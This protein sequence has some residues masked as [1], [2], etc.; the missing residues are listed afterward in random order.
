MGLVV[1]NK[2]TEKVISLP[3]KLFEKDK[4]EKYLHKVV[5]QN[6]DLLST[7]ENEHLYLLGSHLTILGSELD[8]LVVDKN[9]SLGIVELK[10]GRPPRETI[11]QILEYASK[12]KGLSLDELEEKVKLETTFEKIK[13]DYPDFE[14][15]FSEFRELVK[16][17][18]NLG[19][20]SLIVVSYFIDETTKE[21]MDYLRTYGVQISGLEFK[22]FEGDDNEYFV[23][24]WIGEEEVEEILSKESTPA[25]RRNI[26]VFS[27]LLEDFKN[28]NLGVTYAKPGGDS[29]FQIPIGHSNIHLEWA[30][31]KDWVEVGFHIEGPDRELNLKMLEFFQTKKS[32]LEKNVGDKLTF[33]VWGKRWARVYAKKARGDLGK[34][35]RDWMKEKMNTFYK[36]FKPF[37]DEYF[38]SK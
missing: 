10:R 18:L 6:L 24:N 11:A 4:E 29:W 25:Q 12:L 2:K 22:Y 14:I 38:H 5:E 36:A 1:R 37:V 8:L 16:Q 21:I 27:E 7:R 33:E 23:T 19:R 20:F 31:H 26:E 34:E 3:A 9:G 15:S 32:E 17:S 28:K 13:E 35:V 30:I